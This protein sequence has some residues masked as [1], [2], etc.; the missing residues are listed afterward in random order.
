M[1]SLSKGPGGTGRSSHPPARVLMRDVAA[2]ANV[3]AKTVS[4]VINR[5]SGVKAETAERVM[6]AV[7]VLGYERNDL[8]RSLRN[9]RT[10]LTLGLVI[11][12]VSNRFFS[13]LARGVEEMAR[14]RG[15]VVIS[16]NSDDDASLERD[17]VSSLTSRRIDALVI[18]PTAS[19]QAHLS[20]ARATIPVAF[21]DRPAIDGGA[22]TV[23]LDNADAVRRAIK[24][25]IDR[26]HTR[27]GVVTGPTDLY[28][29]RERLA[30]YRGALADAGM[31]LDESLIRAGALHGEAAE[32][33]TRELLAG[34]QPPTALLATN[35]Q[36]TIGAI[37][38]VV[39]RPDRIEIIGFDDFELAD[40]LAVRVTT[41]AHDPVEMGREGARL[42]L[43][44]LSGETGPPRMV[45]LPT[46]LMVRE[47]GP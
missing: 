47:Q 7:T 15:Y 22:D 46:R 40:V 23:L 1:S 5:E 41:I 43:N 24:R 30:G 44:R 34:E 6:Q 17:L 45:V 35:N 42:V 18:V 28:T 19:D 36:M 3:S 10:T 21:L 2:A 14:E 16:G 27:I 12:D 4:R 33:A 9:G 25:L 37:K 8:A 38:A 31:P 11:S 26:G 32:A 39:G 13:L 29:Y 20:R